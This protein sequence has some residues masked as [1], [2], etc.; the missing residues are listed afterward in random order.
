MEK[1]AYSI[2]TVFSEMKTVCL[3]RFLIDVPVT[4][5]VV[6]GFSW[7]P[8]PIYRYAGAG[9]KID[10]M[11]A[12][13]LAEVG[14]DSYREYKELRGSHSM[15]GKVV[16]GAVPG[17]R[18]VFGVGAGSGADYQIHSFVKV[19]DDVFVQE[20]HTSR[21]KVAYDNKIRD[22][23][24][25]ASLLRPRGENEIPSE[26]G[27][28]IGGGFILDP[29]RFQQEALGLGV[30]L[31]E[32]PDVHFSIS[33]TKKDILVPS[34]ALE[35]RLMQGEETLKKEGHGDWLARVKTLRR[36]RHSIGKWNG[37]EFLAWQPAQ[38]TE[39]ESH[40]FVFVSQ[41]APNDP[42]LPLLELEL[43]TGVKGNQVGGVKP[44]L[45]DEEA[46]AVWDHITTSIRVRPVKEMP[47]APAGAAVGAIAL[48]GTRCPQSGWWHCADGSDTIRIQ[49]GARKYFKEGKILPQAVLVGQPTLWQKIRSEKP[50]FCLENPTVWTLV[51]TDVA[52][53]VSAPVVDNADA[54]GCHPDN[55]DEVT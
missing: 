47:E 50:I 38:A 55:E 17:Q 44:S 19:G 49:G 22:F 8:T 32:F 43:R 27:V 39:G 16:K 36:G 42:Y 46:V 41:G 45:T 28:C 11:I 40:E 33:V 23:N 12:D 37:Y 54:D 5:E 21:D 9:N 7:V 2:E 26:A 13:K 34:D 31:R 10:S 3:G 35:P 6:Y 53:T 30:R 14:K 48:S 24:H 4:A 18:I 1:G 25:L 29:K 52:P 51:K 20:A 15:V